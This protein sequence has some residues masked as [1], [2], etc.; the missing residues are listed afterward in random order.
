[1]AFVRILTKLLRDKEIGSKIVPI[2]PDEARTFGMDSLFRS[3]G[4][5][6]SKGQLYEP[7]DSETFLY[8][9]EDKKGQIMVAD[10]FNKRVQVLAFVAR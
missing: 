1:M 2:I 4:I 10:L 5:Y 6:S 3:A 7:V 8:Y 9:R